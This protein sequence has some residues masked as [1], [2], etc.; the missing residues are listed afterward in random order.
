MFF[1]YGVLT[2]MNGNFTYSHIMEN[3]FASVWIPMVLF[4]MGVFAG[5][6]SK[7]HFNPAITLA[8]VFK[9]DERI[10]ISIMW[11]YFAAEFTGAIFGAGIGI[12][13]FI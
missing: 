9:K 1:S 4:S 12:L 11:C 2:G 3:T 5:R 6:F 10:K 8:Y 7:S 13:H